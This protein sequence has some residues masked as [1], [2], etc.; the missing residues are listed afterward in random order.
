MNYDIR[1]CTSF[2]PVH[3]PLKPNNQA[4]IV[5]AASF[6]SRGLTKTCV[7]TVKITDFLYTTYPPFSQSQKFGQQNDKLF[8]S[9]I[10]PPFMAVYTDCPN[11]PFKAVWD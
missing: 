8:R 6:S 5:Q 9:L 7:L 2:A 3:H 10:P 4:V 11:C 1:N